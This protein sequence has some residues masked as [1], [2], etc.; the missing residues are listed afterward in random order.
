MCSL[1]KHVRQPFSSW[2]KSFFLKKQT[3]KKNQSDA[4]AISHHTAIY[5]L[6]T[7]SILQVDCVLSFIHK[8]SLL[9]ISTLS[10]KSH[11]SHHM[12]HS[13]WQTRKSREEESFFQAAKSF[14]RIPDKFLLFG[15]IS[16][17]LTSEVFKQKTEAR[18]IMEKSSKN[19]RKREFLSQRRKWKWMF[20]VS[21]LLFLLWK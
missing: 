15:R 18:I 17:L 11:F 20:S 6:T 13:S 10:R 7:S 3:K 9:R 16:H 5:I 4:H 14:L 19:K 2:E 21:F 8:T 12:S 1:L